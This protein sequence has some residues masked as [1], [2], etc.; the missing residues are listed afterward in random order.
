MADNRPRKRFGQNF[1]TDPDIAG[2]IANALDPAP[3]ERVVEIGPGRGALTRQLLQ[4]LDYLDA[5]EVDRDLI[6]LLQDLAPDS[7]RLTVHRADAT[8]F[9]FAALAEARGGPLRVVG[10]FPY[11]IST[12]L[13]FH[14]LDAG[15]AVAEITCML[16]REVVERLVAGPGTRTY[17]RLSVMVQSECHAT[18][19]FRVSPG[20]F[21]PVPKV[22]SAV[23]RLVR[24]GSEHPRPADPERFATVVARAFATRRK[25]LRN[26]LKGIADADT[27]AEAGIDPG[28]RAE[29][30]APADF[31]RL[32]DRLAVAS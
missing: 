25:T 24:H 12:P 3:D 6:P 31:R 23:V 2:R 29:Q 21:C 11:N 27:L 10:N 17:G 15:P 14:L 22:E 32:A 1:L 9:D 13:L 18:P 7:H 5:I 16:Q 20:A 26:A 28:A 4:R 30:L 8:T 19:L